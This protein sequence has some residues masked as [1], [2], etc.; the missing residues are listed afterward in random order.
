[1][2]RYAVERWWGRARTSGVGRVCPNQVA[3][4]LSQFSPLLVVVSQRNRGGLVQGTGRWGR[5]DILVQVDCGD[6]AAAAISTIA[7][8]QRIIGWPVVVMVVGASHAFARIDA[9]ARARAEDGL[10]VFVVEGRPRRGARG[11]TEAG[12]RT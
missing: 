10:H 9:A 4:L 11:L 12:G 6:D 1:M 8:V 3:P 2:R 5:P 7:S